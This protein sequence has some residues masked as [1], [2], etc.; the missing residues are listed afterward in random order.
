MIGCKIL[1]QQRDAKYGD[2]KR[3]QSTDIV[4]ALL[5]YLQSTVCRK[6][7]P[8]FSNNHCWALEG[9]TLKVALV[10][11]SSPP[12]HSTLGVFSKHKNWNRGFELLKELHNQSQCVWQQRWRH[13]H[14]HSLRKTWVEFREPSLRLMAR[15]LKEKN[16]KA[17]SGT[18][19]RPLDF[20]CQGHMYQGEKDDALRNR[21]Y[22]LKLSRGLS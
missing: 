17:L 1:R 5:C 7:N 8:K 22:Q 20:S 18:V 11:G 15:Q 21:Q 9:L 4:K 2:F 14:R 6:W 10:F 12:Q 3:N 13:I 19:E 16:S